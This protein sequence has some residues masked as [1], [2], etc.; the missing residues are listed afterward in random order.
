LFSLCHD[1]FV[2]FCPFRSFQYLTC[3]YPLSSSDACLWMTFL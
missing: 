3:A 1:H 2:P